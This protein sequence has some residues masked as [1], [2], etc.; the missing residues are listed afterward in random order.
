MKGS[1]VKGLAGSLLLAGSLAFAAGAF[2][3]DGAAAKPD[4]K[5]TKAQCEKEG[6]DKGLTG[7]QLS[8]YVSKCDGTAAKHTMKMKKEEKKEEKKDDAKK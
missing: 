7:K 8:A 1:V 3:A 4:A 5:E 6:K 2:A